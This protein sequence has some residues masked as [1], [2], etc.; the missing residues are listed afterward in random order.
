MVGIVAE[1][2]MGVVAYRA[3]DRFLATDY[4]DFTDGKK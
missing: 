1:K 2:K 4:T 3:L